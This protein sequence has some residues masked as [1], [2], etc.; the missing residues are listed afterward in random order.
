M[1]STSITETAV[2]HDFEREKAVLL[3]RAEEKPTLRMIS[4]KEAKTI[5][6]WKDLYPELA[7]F[8]EVTREDYSQIYEGKLIATAESSIEF[9][10]LHQEYRR[11][12]IVNLTTFGNSLGEGPIPLPAGFW[13]G[14]GQPE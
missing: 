1:P 8:I 2:E 5:E 3:K 9:L 6:E 12:G 10:D 4:A 11:R 14:S 13:L 7:L